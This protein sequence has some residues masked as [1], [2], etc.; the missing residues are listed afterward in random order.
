MAIRIVSVLLLLATTAIGQTMRRDSLRQIVYDQLLIPSAGD[1]QVTS[2][3]FNRI[4]SRGLNAISTS[5]PAYEK[6]DTVEITVAVEGGT[7]G[8]DF[9]AALSVEKIVGQTIR[10]PLQVVP[11]ADTLYNLLG[12]TADKTT[13]NKTLREHPRYYSAFNG[14]LFAWPKYSKTTETDSFL[15]KYFAKAPDVTLDSTATVISTA[16][17]EALIYFCCSKVS[18]LRHDYGAGRYYYGM[19]LAEIRRRGMIGGNDIQ[20]IGGYIAPSAGATSLPAAIGVG[21]PAE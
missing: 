14:K 21:S 19:Y 20:A 13:M 12:G 7:L 5:C 16:Y 8:S 6:L 10:I 18:D 9:V 2:A 17:R 15:V 11:Y 3:R 1:E 4:F